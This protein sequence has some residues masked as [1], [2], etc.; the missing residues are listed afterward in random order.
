MNDRLPKLRELHSQFNHGRVRRVED[1]ADPQS[2]EI[3]VSDAASPAPAGFG[4][5]QLESFYGLISQVKLNTYKLTQCTKK[6][7]HVGNDYVKHMDKDDETKQ[8]AEKALNKEKEEA[9]NITSSTG[10]T[11]KELDVLQVLAA[12]G[13]DEDG[14]PAQR[15]IDSSSSSARIKWKE[16]A[17]AY[18]DAER[19][20]DT[21]LRERI[22]RY[23]EIHEDRK[24]TQEEVDQKMDEGVQDIFAETMMSKVTTNPLAAVSGVAKGHERIPPAVPLTA[25]PPLCR[26]IFSWH[27]A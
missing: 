23:I 27:V 20:I 4:E 13:S 2:V 9:A 18:V 14:A 26:R 22:M 21:I 6:L 10:K 7:K 3:D 17:K 5:S 25:V 15:M 16:A 8:A 1:E 24:P 11:F 19:A 12:K